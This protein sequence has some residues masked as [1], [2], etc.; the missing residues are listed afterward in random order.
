[1]LILWTF[2]LLV[3]MVCFV[4]FGLDKA[5]A[6]AGQHRI[7]EASLLMLAL[8]GG[9]PGGKLAQHLFHHKT[10]KSPFCHLMNAIPLCWIAVAAVTW[11][12]LLL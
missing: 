3:N 8:F 6:L 12:I 1:M 11:G 10:R 5:R 4:A 9:W 7:S 2:V